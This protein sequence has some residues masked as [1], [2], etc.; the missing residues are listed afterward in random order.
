MI[1]VLVLLFGFTAG[2]QAKGSK[3]CSDKTIVYVKPK[4]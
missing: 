2:Y 4:G 1:F 3:E